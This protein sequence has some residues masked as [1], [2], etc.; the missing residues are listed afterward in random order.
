M[1]ISQLK[2][3]KVDWHNHTYIVYMHIF[4]IQS[5]AVNAAN[6]INNIAI[7][8]IEAEIQ[9]KGKLGLFSALKGLLSQNQ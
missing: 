3:K 9:L 5:I 1:N 7:S 2:K 8:R 4:Y 6:L